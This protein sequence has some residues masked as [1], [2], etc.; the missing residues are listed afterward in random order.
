MPVFDI[1]VAFS[2]K[3]ETED[4]AAKTLVDI[5]ARKRLTGDDTLDSPV[6]CWWTPNH[7][8]ADRSDNEAILAFIRWDDTVTAYGDDA[9]RQ[10]Q[11]DAM[12]E[13][14]GDA[15]NLP[16]DVG[17]PLDVRF[18]L[19]VSTIARAMLYRRATAGD[20]FEG[21]ATRR[22]LAS[23]PAHAE[24]RID[25]AIGYGFDAADEVAFELGFR[26]R[27]EDEDIAEEGVA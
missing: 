2:V 26:Y 14:V 18:S 21:Y 4:E 13:R 9:L 10:K 25:D 6:E 15:L 24:D 8:A 5:L 11:V 27:D 20:P 22:Q 16:D 7:P 17:V 1:P 19:A 12:V 23:I 3:G